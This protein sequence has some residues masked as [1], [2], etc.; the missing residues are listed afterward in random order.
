MS[1]INYSMA[2]DDVEEL[3]EGLPYRPDV[4]GVVDVSDNQARY[5]SMGMGLQHLDRAI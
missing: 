3:V 5:G 4:M 1:S 2:Y